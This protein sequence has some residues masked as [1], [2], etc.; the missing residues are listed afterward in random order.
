MARL[1]IETSARH[2][3]GY[4]APNCNTGSQTKKASPQRVPHPKLKSYRTV[5]ALRGGEGRNIQM[6]GAR[7]SQTKQT[8]NRF[9]SLGLHLQ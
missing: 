6:L 3:P 1:A 9:E 5:Q 4:V 2:H 8:K 7:Q